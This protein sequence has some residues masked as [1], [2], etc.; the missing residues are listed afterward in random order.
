MVTKGRSEKSSVIFLNLGKHL[1]AFISHLRVFNELVLCPLTLKYAP[2]S[3]S[4]VLV[5]RISS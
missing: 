4:F 3:L 1:L 5:R 2:V